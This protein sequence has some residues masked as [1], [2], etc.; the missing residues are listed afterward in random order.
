MSTPGLFQAWNI[1]TKPS[2][3]YNVLRPVRWDL[4]VFRPQSSLHDMGEL[5]DR[6]SD[7]LEMC[8][9]LERSICTA[10]SQEEAGQNCCY[11][12]SFQAYHSTE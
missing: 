6:M 7:A 12:N 11:L 8:S 5:N 10:Y 4:L 1:D 9:V 2:T 3:D